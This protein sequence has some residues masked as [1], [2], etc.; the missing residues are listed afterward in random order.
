MPQ[1]V[2]FPPHLALG[3]INNTLAKIARTAPIQHRKG[4]PNVLITGKCAHNCDN[5]PLQMLPYVL[6]SYLLLLG[7]EGYCYLSE[8][9]VVV[10]LFRPLIS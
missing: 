6:L 2:D 8:M 3:S 1:T 7:N 9:Q 4:T 5:S 10:L